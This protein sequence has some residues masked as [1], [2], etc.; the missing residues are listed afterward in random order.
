MR[1]AEVAS[2]SVAASACPSS[3]GHVSS[4]RS[5]RYA[6]VLLTSRFQLRRTLLIAHR[7]RVIGAARFRIKFPGKRTYLAESYR[8]PRRLEEP[9]PAKHPS[10]ILISGLND[11]RN[12]R[13]QNVTS[14]YIFHLL[15]GDTQ[16]RGCSVAGPLLAL[17][18]HVIVHNL[19]PR[20][21][22]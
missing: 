19:R 13:S 8:T 7:Y 3:A 2:I 11:H 9:L 4:I 5:C 21:H 22:I 6:A 14:P 17:Q 1:V 18:A 10:S 15:D 16:F 12:T 20:A